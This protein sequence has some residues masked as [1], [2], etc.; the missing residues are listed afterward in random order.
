MKEAAIIARCRRRTVSRNSENGE[1]GP[2]R[3][4][5]AKPTAAATARSTPTGRFSLGERVHVVGASAARYFRTHVGSRRSSTI[6]LA[7]GAPWPHRVAVAQVRALVR[8]DVRLHERL[9]EPQCHRWLVA[10]PRGRR[11]AE[12]GG[13]PDS[14]ALTRAP[15]SGTTR[16]GSPVASASTCRAQRSTPRLCRSSAPSRS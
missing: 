13:G 7:N 3:P 8:I 2:V 16:P 11:E 9:R 15:A 6:R 5:L 12:P 10:R 1:P 14:A 4:G